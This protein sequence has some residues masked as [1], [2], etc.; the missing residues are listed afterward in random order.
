MADDRVPLL[1]W[2]PRALD[3]WLTRTEDWSHAL[4]AAAGLPLH[5]RMLLEMLEAFAGRFVGDSLE[6][7]TETTWVRLALDAVEILPAGAVPSP[8]ATALDAP[9]VDLARDLWSIV[10]GARRVTKM[11]EQS[12]QNVADR[13]ERLRDPGRVR[14][15]AHSVELAD[16]VLDRVGC[17]VEGL[18]L[19]PGRVPV[20][21]SGR[22]DLVVQIARPTMAAWIERAEPGTAVRV[23]GDRITVQP[24]GR[25]WTFT[26]EPSIAGTELQARVVRVRR[27]RV[28]VGLPDR[29]VRTY[30]VPIPAP[31]PL[32][33]IDA[34]LGDELVVR[35]RHPGIRHPVHPD[36]VRELIAQGTPTFSLPDLARR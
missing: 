11:V 34:A 4:S 5:R 35:Y 12:V 8:V 23:D 30:S 25:K 17:F 13:L 1:P 31:E 10:P 27:G 26:V 22:I 32:T 3:E 15:D 9:L 7:S 28:D 14:L 24:A 2:G 6:V 19:E 21:A 36:R 20:L 18:R 29:F 33:V 16:G